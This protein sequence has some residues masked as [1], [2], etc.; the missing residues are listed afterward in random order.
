MRLFLI[1][2]AT[3]A[4]M[5][6]LAQ[7]AP[8]KD[9]S[10]KAELSLVST[11]GNAESTTFGF[12]NTLDLKREKGEFSLSLG[13]IRAENKVFTRT[14]VGTLDD[15]TVNE[16]TRTEKTDERA[17]L[18]AKYA[19]KLGQ[20]MALVM[21]FDW[22]RN[23]FAGI[24]NR[25]ALSLGVGHTWWD[26]DASTFKTDYALQYTQ[27]DPV[28][29]P[30]AFDDNYTSLK[31]GYSYR[32]QIT[33]NTRFDQALNLIP[34]L[35]ESDDLRGDLDNNLSV[36]INKRLALKIGVH[37]YYDKDPAYEAVPLN[38]EADTTVPFQLDEWDRLI[39]TTLVVNF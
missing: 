8:E 37:L 12:K 34:N 36:S 16:E 7:D 28:Y 13:A 22:D 14:A 30:P 35:E 20:R 18:N 17:Y 27:E 25:Y 39:T 38:G 6:T 2:I 33:E 15:Y 9:W 11:S 24:K 26:H 29:E 5:P 4:L 3:L 21:G 31:L 1:S 23:E 19:F 32:R 10:N